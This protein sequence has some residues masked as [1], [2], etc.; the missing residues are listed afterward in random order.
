MTHADSASVQQWMNKRVTFC[1]ERKTI[2]G[3][4]Q[5]K[6][7]ENG[8]KATMGKRSAAQCPNAVGTEVEVTVISWNSGQNRYQVEL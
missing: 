4:Y 6:I 7:K 1:C 5:G 8:A 2:N 3:T